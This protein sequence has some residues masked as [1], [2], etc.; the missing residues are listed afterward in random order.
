MINVECQKSCPFLGQRQK[1][2]VWEIFEI[3]GDNDGKRGPMKT[4]LT[5]LILSASS[6]A[7]AGKGLNAVNVSYPSKLSA[8]LQKQYG[9]SPVANAASDI[10]SQD[11]LTFETSESNSDFK[12]LLDGEETPVAKKLSLSAGK[13]DINAHEIDKLAIL[14]EQT[15]SNQLSAVRMKNGTVKFFASKSVSDSDLNSLACKGCENFGAGYDFV[16]KVKSPRD[17]NSGLATGR[18]AGT[19]LATGEAAKIITDR[20]SGRSKG[21]SFV[22]TDDELI[23][24]WADLYISAPEQK[25]VVEFE[26][27]NPRQLS[28]LQKAKT[29]KLIVP[30]AMEKG[31]MT[32]EL[33]FAI[34]ENGIKIAI[35]GEDAEVTM[36]VINKS[37]SNVKNN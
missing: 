23:S 14:K 8:A 34:K 27:F 1:L 3:V 32:M 36:T 20:D 9:P 18:D 24:T 17:S 13:R 33:G 25:I 10:L 7:Y 31:Y 12:I 2:F 6:F 30:V 15:V 21:F 29:I 37:K 5:V 16:Y 11:L 4:I 22:V 28:E 26:K 19:G 35:S